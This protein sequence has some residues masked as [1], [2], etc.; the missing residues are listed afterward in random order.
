MSRRGECDK[1]RG[2]I[3]DSNASTLF[4]EGFSCGDLAVGCMG[5][6]VAGCG[7][8]FGIAEIR[9]VRFGKFAWGNFSKQI[10][11]LNTTAMN[12]TG[13][14]LRRNTFPTLENDSHLCYHLYS[15]T[16][17]GAF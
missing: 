12:T 5:T 16:Q 11:T 4:V 8:E 3:S 1:L 17:R 6:K 14:T 15:H 7:E 10:P 9:S 2:G 13:Y